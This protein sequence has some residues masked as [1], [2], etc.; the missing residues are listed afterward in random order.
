[1][2]VALAAMATSALAVLVLT[3][4][5][6]PLLRELKFGQTIRDDGPKGHLKK[7]GTPTM[8]GIIFLPAAILSL[9]LWG[10]GSPASWL[11]ICSFAG[12]ALIGLYDDLLK[13][14][15]HRSLGL[16]ARG[17]LLL[18]FVAAFII[19]YVSVR[20]L[21]RGTEIIFPVTG[22]TIDL[23]WA[24]YPLMAVFFVGM[25]NAVNLTDG[26]DGLASGV[27]F[28]VFMGMALIGLS[29]LNNP[30]V[31]G[32][33]Y[34]DVYIAAA[35]IAG[36][37]LGFLF[38]NRYPA[39][40]FMGDTGALAL[41]GALMILT[42]LTK[43]EIV[44]IVLGGIYLVE[45]L[46]VILQVSSFRFMGKR[47]FLMAPLHHHFEMKGWKETKVVAVFWSVTIFLVALA[48]LLITV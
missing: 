22:W 20:V 26:L 45:A 42:I 38:F 27:S 29:A 6:I 2:K 12:Y 33:D 47:L 14:A 43:T 5:L 1:M 4:L 46:S 48:L 21:G 31:I 30:P 44:L 11:I 25:V 40:V 35:A 13:V 19:I 15:F 39:K 8:G 23:G 36:A 32:L 41:G 24:Y 16:K 10:N 37:C 34:T 9:L 17:K 3:P 28:L 18:Q 7:A